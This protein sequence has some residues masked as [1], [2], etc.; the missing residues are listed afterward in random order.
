MLGKQARPAGELPLAL[1]QP[2]DART[3]RQQPSRSGAAALEQRRQQ[4]LPRTRTGSP[5]RP[6]RHAS[7][8]ASCSGAGGCCSRLAA[9]CEHAG[10]AGA[11]G[12]RP[13]AHTTHDYY[14]CAAATLSHVMMHLNAL[15]WSVI[16]H[17]GSRSCSCSG[18]TSAMTRGGGSLMSSSSPWVSERVFML[19]VCRACPACPACPACLEPLMA[20]MP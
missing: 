15:R 10:A 14:A 13:F 4:P 5:P 6:V 17:A 16:R 12:A 2:A 19:C 8:H 20:C 7:R 1:E 3:Q 18:R 11:T 9:M